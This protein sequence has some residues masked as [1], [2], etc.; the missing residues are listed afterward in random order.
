MCQLPIY[1]QLP[2]FHIYGVA[3]FT[4]SKKIQKSLSS[5][6]NKEREKK[7]QKGKKRAPKV[8]NEER[9]VIFIEEKIISTSNLFV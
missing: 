5:S 8:S 6:S 7:C 4:P 3:V 1:P 9:D 2:P